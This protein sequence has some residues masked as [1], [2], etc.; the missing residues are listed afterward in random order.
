MHWQSMFTSLITVWDTEST[1]KSIFVSKQVDFFWFVYLGALLFNFPGK[2][3]SGL[4]DFWCF[5]AN[6]CKLVS[7]QGTQ[8]NSIICIYLSKWYVYKNYNSKFKKKS[9]FIIWFYLKLVI[10]LYFWILYSILLIPGIQLSCADLIK[11]TLFKINRNIWASV[12]LYHVVSS[13]TSFSTTLLKI[14]IL[15]KKTLR[16][17]IWETGN[18]KKFEV[19]YSKQSDTLFPSKSS[20]TMLRSQTFCSIAIFIVIMTIDV[21][22]A[23]G[24]GRSQASR[25][26]SRNNYYGAGDEG[27]EFYM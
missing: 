22:E 6:K 10:F 24:G 26:S 1:S 11:P 15:W 17:L 20:E 19:T 14:P 9:K 7:Y 13:P 12:Q 2:L 3:F 5:L 27:K 16:F 25:G 23:K 21:C 18:S 4:R 8:C